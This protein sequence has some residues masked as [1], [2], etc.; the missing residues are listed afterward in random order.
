MGRPRKTQPEPKEV[1]QAPD[2]ITKA[3][4]Y[5]VAPPVVEAT[6]AVVS[7]AKRN[8]RHPSPTIRNRNVSDKA[9]VT[10]FLNEINRQFVKPKVK[11]DEELAARFEQY[12]RDCATYGTVPTIEELFFSTGYT[13]GHMNDIMLGND[14]GFSPET[15]NII[16]R[17]KEY[18]KVFDAKLLLAG[19]IDFVAYCFRGKNFYE[20]RDQQDI[21][22]APRNPLG[23]KASPQQLEAKYVQGLDDDN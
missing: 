23:E 8:P 6:A 14:R 18:Q 19:K 11:S 12:Y 2:A 5:A 4:E 21:V 17:A 9:M 22:V 3:V 1:Q 20:M 7:D 10:Q 13:Y 15:K 16:K